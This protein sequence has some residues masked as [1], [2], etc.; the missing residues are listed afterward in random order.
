MPNTTSS[1]RHNNII[2]GL[3]YIGKLIPVGV[4][5]FGIYQFNAQQNKNSVEDFDRRMLENTLE[6]YSK[7]TQIVG[8]IVTLQ[9]PR[10]STIYDSLQTAFNERYWGSLLLVQ[11]DDVRKALKGLKAEI[12]DVRNGNGEMRNIMLRQD[13]LAEQFRIAL[14]TYRNPK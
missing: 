9:L 8:K 14:K 1:N 3:D 2:N 6:S 5:I 4:F 7:V 10:D 11:Q 13:H 12:K